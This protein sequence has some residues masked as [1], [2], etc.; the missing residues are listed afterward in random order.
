M[1]AAIR[2]ASANFKSFAGGPFG[3]CIV[4]NGRIIAC[5]GNTV[6]NGDATCHAEINAIRMA[7]QKLKSYDL[8]GCVIYSTTEP[9]PMCFG[10]VHW[11]RIGKIFYGTTI[12]DAAAAGF[13]EL[14]ISCARLNGLGRAG[15]ALYPG[16]M[17]KECE[18]LFG[19][20][21]KSAPPGNY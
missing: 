8:S 3:A 11:A 2:A 7:S 13:N 1:A 14:K 15:I 5:A 9:C 6:L 19:R 20:W 18:Q 4:K 17:R 10:A 12:A 21:Q 16:L